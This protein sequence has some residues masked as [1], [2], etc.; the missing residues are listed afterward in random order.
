[1][2]IQLSNDGDDWNH[3][4]DWL[5]VL[6]FVKNC[7]RYLSPEPVDHGAP[8]EPSKALYRRFE[9]LRERLLD[10][11][12]PFQL[13]CNE[14]LQYEQNLPADR[15]PAPQHLVVLTQIEG[16]SFGDHLQPASPSDFV[17]QK[18]RWVRDADIFA[19]HFVASWQMLMMQIVE[20]LSCGIVEGRGI[21]DS[22]PPGKFAVRE[23]IP[24][25]WW[26]GAAL[27]ANKSS[28]I[29]GN[30]VVRGL[31]LRF[32]EP[33]HRNPDSGPSKQNAAGNIGRP[34]P[35]IEIFDALDQARASG[36]TRV[37]P[38]GDTEVMAK[39]AA[40]ATG[41]TLGVSAGWKPGTPQRH[42][43]EWKNKR[44]TASANQNE[45]TET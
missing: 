39:I 3:W 33:Q 34:S 21:L 17:Q 4:S 16:A 18:E 38:D 36:D 2:R 15:G 37:H 8:N 22:T 19:R 28:A 41:N 43:N 7:A 44:R 35:R 32:A 1:M 5:E 31:E 11:P 30:Q 9:Y 29:A 42:V 23:P 14:R 10:F 13:Y 20:Q 12:E 26:Q 24:K 40:S 25:E 6:P 45:N 27:Y